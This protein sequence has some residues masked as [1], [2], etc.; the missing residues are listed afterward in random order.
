VLKDI[1]GNAKVGDGARRI[2]RGPFRGLR[3]YGLTLE[4]RATCPTTCDNWDRCY[5]D[6]MPFARR[7]R[8]G[9]RLH[10]ALSAD[11][12]TLA[13]RH[14]EGFVVRLHILG[15]FYSEAYV[16]HWRLLLAATPGLRIFGYTHWPPDT[17]IGRAVTQLVQDWPGRVR[18]LRSDGACDDP[19]PRAMTVPHDG[20]AVPGT[21]VCPEQTGR[22]RS[23]LTCGLCMNGRTSV[24]FLD[25]SRRAA[26]TTPA[27]PPSTSEPPVCPLPTL[28]GRGSPG[29]RAL[30][31][32]GAA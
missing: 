2:V 20:A 11:V 31:V 15:D 1:A 8:P 26:G 6:N 18:I 24:S 19:L 25:H 3:L 16:A 13:A 22:T 28:P 21:V 29:P 12:A 17:P 9:G 7:Y 23:C 4:E 30:P 5:G 32:R 27:P 14:P 10:R